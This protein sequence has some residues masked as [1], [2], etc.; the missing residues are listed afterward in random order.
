MTF[1]H[2]TI[3]LIIL[4]AVLIALHYS[5]SRRGYFSPYRPGKEVIEI[6]DEKS[7]LQE[8]FDV[9]KIAVPAL[10]IGMIIGGLAW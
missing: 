5:K 4:C 8:F 2:W 7:Y 9:L 10:I 3:L 1:E 6:W